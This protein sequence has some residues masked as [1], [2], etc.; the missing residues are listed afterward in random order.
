[1]K[2]DLTPVKNIDSLPKHVNSPGT[3][4]AQSLFGGAKEIVIRH[5]GDDY[6]L[7]ITR[8]DKLILTK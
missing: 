3:V 6:R 8:N 4:S 5:Q 2:P 7:R 1:M